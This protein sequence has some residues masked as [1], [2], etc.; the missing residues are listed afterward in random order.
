MSPATTFLVLGANEYWNDAELD[1]IGSTLNSQTS[2]PIYVHFTSGEW[3]GALKSWV[4]GLVYQ[5]GFGL[6]EQ[7]VEDRT[8]ELVA[9]M[10]Q[11]GKTFIA[12]EY[13]FKADDATARRLGDAALRGGAQRFANGELRAVRGYSDSHHDGP[14]GHSGLHHDDGGDGGSGGHRR[15]RQRRAADDQEEEMIAATLKGSA[16]VRQTKPPG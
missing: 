11:A 5:Y 8:R 7:Q 13:A 14:G 1:R 15:K 10:Q 2:K 12:G 4:S 3:K 9:R 6:T 16:Y